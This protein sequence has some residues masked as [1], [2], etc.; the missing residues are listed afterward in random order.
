MLNSP[1]DGSANQLN[2]DFV[3]IGKVLR[4]QGNRGEIR[5]LPITNSAHELLQLRTDKFFVH[6][7]RTSALQSVT[8]QHMRIHQQF[9]ILKLAECNSLEDAKSLAGKSVYVQEKDRCDLPPDHYYSDQLIGL[10]VIDASTHGEIGVVSTIIYGSAHDILVVKRGSREILVPA[11]K[12][13]V[14]SVSLESGTMEVELP[15]GLDE[16]N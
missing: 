13:M 9:V 16:L 7:P 14:R 11:V 15:E 2:T 10:R 6:D 3:L 8:L 5:L 1:L 4:P 12:E